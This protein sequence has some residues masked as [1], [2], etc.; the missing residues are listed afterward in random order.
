MRLSFYLLVSLFAV[1]AALNAATIGISVN[2]TCEAG[3]CPP[4]PLPFSTTNTIPV[5]FFFTLANGDR[6]L[7]NGSSTETNDAPGVGFSIGHL[8]QVTYEGNPAGGPSAADTISVEQFDVLQTIQSSVVFGRDLIGAFGPTIAASS[9]ASSC[10]IGTL[11]CL[12]PIRPPGSF[13]LTT[14]LT[15]TLDSSGN[16]FTYDPAFVNNFGAGSPVGSFI[17]WGQTAPLAAPTPEPAGVDL[18]AI[19]LAAIIAGRARLRR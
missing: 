19:G 8:F 12:G 15:L 5:D 17:V 7:I 9:S 13:N 18:L 4:A 10:V 2:G 1:T 11:G 3:S 6:Y 16:T 14:A